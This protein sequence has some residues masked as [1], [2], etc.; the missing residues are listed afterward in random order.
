[1]PT[2]AFSD[3][4]PPSPPPGT[5]ACSCGSRTARRWASR[6]LPAACSSRP[7]SNSS[8]SRAPLLPSPP[9]A[10][11]I[12]RACPSATPLHPLPRTPPSHPR[13]AAIHILSGRAHLGLASRAHVNSAQPRHFSRNAHPSAPPCDPQGRRGACRH[14]RGGGPP[15]D[16]RR[17]R[18]RRGERPTRVARVLDALRAHRLLAGAV[19]PSACARTGVANCM[20]SA[21]GP[22]D[23]RRSALTAALALPARTLRSRP[24]ASTSPSLTRSVP[25]CLP[26]HRRRCG[27]S[28]R[29]R[30]PSVRRPTCQSPRASR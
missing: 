10:C 19:R 15:L 13:P 23:L 24:P 5:R 26:R 25:P 11:Q 28:A 20:R 27:L 2:P 22:R 29:S 16:H 6:C 3:P 30:R 21:V 8:T 1:M 18:G 9:P 17:R 12:W 14:A 7:P 4:A